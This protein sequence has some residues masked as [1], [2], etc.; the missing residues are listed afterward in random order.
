MVAPEP[1]QLLPVEQ[2]SLISLRPRAANVSFMRKNLKNKG[3]KS[4]FFWPH[5]PEISHQV[6]SL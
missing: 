2:P 1:N 3:K 6:T 4:F 5:L